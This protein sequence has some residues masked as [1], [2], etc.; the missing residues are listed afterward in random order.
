MA[1]NFN[2][3]VESFNNAAASEYQWAVRERK[4]IYF[5]RW[6]HIQR[7][8][9]KELF[10]EDTYSRLKCL[11]TGEMNL[12]KRTVNTI[13]TIYNRDADRKLIISEN[14]ESGEIEVDDTYD[15]IIKK[16]PFD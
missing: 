14:E 6:E 13:S 3:I 5:D 7:N 11:I 8:A 1:Q 15:E 12:M 16:I 2:D 4:D 9:L 10:S